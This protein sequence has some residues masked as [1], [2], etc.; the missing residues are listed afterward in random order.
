MVA[1][2]L[3]SAILLL[4]LGRRADKW[5][6]ILGVIASWASFVVGVVI[7]VQMLGL[8]A[9]ERRLSIDLFS[10]IPAGDLS[11]NF[12]TLIDPLSMTFVML[13][14]FVGSLI[15][16]YAIAYMEHDR[17]RRRFFAYLNFFIA[18]MLT[19]VIANSYAV[20]F[21]GWEGVGLASYLLIG[22]WNQGPRN[23]AAHRRSEVAA[24][25]GPT[26]RPPRRRRLS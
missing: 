11:I 9:G 16:V 3:A 23:S 10:W 24:T 22:F 4:V 13:V 7:L 26:M 25:R 15:H 18:S 14:T 21:M 2:P 17:D 5:G 20:L 6:H 8:P 12:G 1:I 19:L